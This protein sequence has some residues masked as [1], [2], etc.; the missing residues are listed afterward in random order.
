MGTSRSCS[1]LIFASS[2]LLTTMKRRFPVCCLFLELD[3]AAL[4]VNIHPA[5]REVKFHRESEVRRLVAQAIHQTILGFHA[6]GE[7]RV[8]TPER[9][10]LQTDLATGGSESGRQ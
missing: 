10:A 8:Q 9:K 4:D 2:H 7:A 6:T 5:K 3:P 1:R